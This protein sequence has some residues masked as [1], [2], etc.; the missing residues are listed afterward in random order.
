MAVLNRVIALKA[1]LIS[2]EYMTLSGTEIRSYTLV[3]NC[4]ATCGKTSYTL[5]TRCYATCGHTIFR[6]TFRQ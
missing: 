1:E 6:E 2:V 5:V 3:T 4:Y